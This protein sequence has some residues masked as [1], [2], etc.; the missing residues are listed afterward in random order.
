MDRSAA[1]RA[2]QPR[3][4][5]VILLADKIEFSFVEPE[6][7]ARETFVD[8]NFAESDL[9]ELRAAFGA[10]HEVEVSGSLPFVSQE[11]SLPLLG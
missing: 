1:K 5:A 2:Q 11:R 8:A 7:V 3:H 4:E 9:T 6:A 10:L